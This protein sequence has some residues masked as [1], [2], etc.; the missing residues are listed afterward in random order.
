MRESLTAEQMVIRQ[1]IFLAL[2]RLQEGSKI[3]VTEKGLPFN[4]VNHARTFKTERAFGGG[5]GVRFNGVIYDLNNSTHELEPVGSYSPHEGM[6]GAL[7][8]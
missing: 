6:R 2:E 3:R 8:E 7:W 1:Y 4:S 5:L